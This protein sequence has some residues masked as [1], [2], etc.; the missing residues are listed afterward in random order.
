MKKVW[1]YRKKEH[2][3]GPVTRDEIQQLLDKGTLDET[4][5]VWTESLGDWVAVSELEHFHFSGLDITPTVAVDKPV[6]YSRETDD[7]NS[8]PRPWVRYWARMIDYTLFAFVVGICIGLIRVSM[9]GHSD[10]LETYLSRFFDSRFSWMG[11]IFLWVF[12]EAI[13]LSTWGATPGKWLFKTTVRNANREKLSF[14]D[15]INRSLSVWWLGVGAGIPFVSLVTLI[16]AAV[17]LSNTGAT[18]W[19]RRSHYCVNH[20]KIGAGRIFIA[21]LFFGGIILSALWRLT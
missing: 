1:F 19:D 21:I 3:E 7:S 5:L 10:Q 11:V 4:T 6:D 18:S 9:R 2:K 14:S 8:K 13:L 12:V 16:V 15:A 17:K 20:S